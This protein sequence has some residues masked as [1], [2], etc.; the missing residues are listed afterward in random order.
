[1][2]DAIAKL[3]DCADD[4]VPHHEGRPVAHCLRVEVT[5]DQHIGV[6]QTRR[7]HAHSDL[8]TPRGRQGSIDHLQCI[9]AAEA[10]DLN[11]PVA[12]LFHRPSLWSPADLQDKGGNCPNGPP[13]SPRYSLSGSL[14]D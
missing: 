3:I 11:N 14:T 7:E 12:R 8:A 13:I 6:F 10:P 5:S 4:V 1:T 9:G 2:A